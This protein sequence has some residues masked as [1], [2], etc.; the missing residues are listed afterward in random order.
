[1]PAILPIEDDDVS[2]E[3]TKAFKKSGIT[4]MTG[5]SV[6]SVDASGKRIGTGW[7][8]NR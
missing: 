7:C 4:V 6:E 1:L 8:K 2:K 5:A 3:I